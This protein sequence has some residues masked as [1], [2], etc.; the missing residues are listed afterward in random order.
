MS[1]QKEEMSVY[2]KAE[3][4][5]RRSELKAG[6]NMRTPFTDN[7]SLQIAITLTSCFKYGMRFVSLFACRVPRCV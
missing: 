4:R 3:G 2:Q 6:E 7:S 1:A 5:G